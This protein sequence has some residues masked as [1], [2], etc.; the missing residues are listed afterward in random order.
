MKSRRGDS[1]RIGGV[2]PATLRIGTGSALRS[3]GSNAD[4]RGGVAVL[5]LIAVVGVAIIVLL[6]IVN[7]GGDPHGGVA[8][9]V[10]PEGSTK[11]PVQL[12]PV[13]DSRRPQGATRISVDRD[14][15]VEDSEDDQ[16]PTLSQ[17]PRNV[18]D[19]VAMLVPS[20][21][22]VASTL[23][24]HFAPRRWVARALEELG[25]ADPAVRSEVESIVSE[26][27]ERTHLLV[28]EARGLAATLY[29]HHVRERAFEVVRS[30][31]VEA[32]SSPAFEDRSDEEI[33]GLTIVREVDGWVVDASFRASAYPDLQR[34]LEVLAEEARVRD[35]QIKLALPSR[36]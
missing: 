34:A 19:R 24:R 18:A 6:T 11:S 33:W 4:R 1:V 30:P 2:L 25:E 8:V 32:S 35:E 36:W 3:S 12:A 17:L 21:D 14:Q 10:E 9:L 5:A 13:S 28:E 15:S 31:E 29:A 22:A 26:H 7:A 20:G 16:G 27:E 23:P